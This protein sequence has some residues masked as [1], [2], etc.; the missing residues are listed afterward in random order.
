LLK[1]APKWSYWLPAVL[2][3]LAV[4]LALVLTWLFVVQPGLGN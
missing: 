4:V 1:R 2:V 3:S